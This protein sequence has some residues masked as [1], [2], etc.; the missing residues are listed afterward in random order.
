MI[1]Y[2]WFLLLSVKCTELMAKNLFAVE[3]VF[4]LPTVARKSSNARSQLD[5]SAPTAEKRRQHDTLNVN[6][7]I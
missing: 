3:K 1:I 2:K 4:V 7:N 5:A 6:K